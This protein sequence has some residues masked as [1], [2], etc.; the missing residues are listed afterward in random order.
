MVQ[1]IVQSCGEVSGPQGDEYEDGYLM[2]CFTL[3]SGTC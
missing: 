3:W 1:V 2:G